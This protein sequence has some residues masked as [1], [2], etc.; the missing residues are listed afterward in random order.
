MSKMTK[1]LGARYIEALP[2]HYALLEVEKL[3]AWNNSKK[4]AYFF[5][6]VTGE[7]PVS[8]LTAYIYGVYKEY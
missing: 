1:K 3:H 6:R 2:L 7:K 5:E 4:W 8:N